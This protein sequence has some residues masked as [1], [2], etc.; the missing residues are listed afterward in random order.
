LDL[1]GRQN[2]LQGHPKIHDVGVMGLPDERLGG[3]VVAVIHLKP[4][5]VRSLEIENEIFQFCAMNL[6]RYK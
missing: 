5:V 4:D 2:T 6:P 1:S 3:M